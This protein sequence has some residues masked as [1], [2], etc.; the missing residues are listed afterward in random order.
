M[1]GTADKGRVV[2][3]SARSALARA[4]GALAEPCESPALT[5]PLACNRLTARSPHA[6]RRAAEHSK[7]TDCLGAGHLGRSLNG[8]EA[9]AVTIRAQELSDRPTDKDREH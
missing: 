3:R 1:D 2:G 9:D 6:F 4:E 8:V 5:P 7:L